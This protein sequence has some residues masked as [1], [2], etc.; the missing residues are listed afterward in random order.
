MT[1]AERLARFVVVE[2]DVRTHWVDA[3]GRREPI[4]SWR[5]VLVAGTSRLT[6]VT[7]DGRD[8][9]EA[10]ATTLRQ[11]FL[12]PL[13]AQ[14]IEAERHALMLR[15]DQWWREQQASV[16]TGGTETK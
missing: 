12:R 11:D 10:Y 3:H 1:L 7:L 2:P 13:C 9:C 15:L 4:V 5:V 16:A 14:F 8:T 6:L